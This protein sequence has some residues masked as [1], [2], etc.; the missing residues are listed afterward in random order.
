MDAI[1]KALQSLP[2]RDMALT[3]KQL[4]AGTKELLRKLPKVLE[5][6][7]YREALGLSQGSCVPCLGNFP[8]LTG[9]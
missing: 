5:L 3:Y 9:E 2:I 8:S 7:K 4:S 6:E 1:V